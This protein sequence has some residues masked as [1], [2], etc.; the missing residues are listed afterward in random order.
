MSPEIM[1]EV[2]KLKDTPYYNLR[3]TSQFSIGPVY[4]V[5]NGTESALFLGPKIWE[6]IPAVIT[7]KESLDGFEREIKKWKP[8][9]CPCRICNMFV[10]D[11]GFI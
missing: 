6:Q 1:S 10:P 3:H 4:S 5:Y 7:N 8:V 2:F 11:L 9:E